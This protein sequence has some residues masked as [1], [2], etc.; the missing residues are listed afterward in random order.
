[1]PTWTA[2][3]PN[4]NAVA[5]VPKGAVTSAMSSQM[6]PSSGGILSSPLWPAGPCLPFPVSGPP[7]PASS[8]LW[9]QWSLAFPPVGPILG[10]A[11]SGWGMCAPFFA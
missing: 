4:S 5:L 7:S 11:R 6:A 3:V 1:M 2:H 9:P 8:V 10:L